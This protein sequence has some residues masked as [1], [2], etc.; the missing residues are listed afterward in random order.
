MMERPIQGAEVMPKLHK[1]QREG[2]AQREVLAQNRGINQ[3]CGLA[4]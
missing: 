3:L 2:M 4:A 1:G